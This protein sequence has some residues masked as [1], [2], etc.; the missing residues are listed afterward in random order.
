MRAAHL[1]KLAVLLHL[2]D[3]AV[4]VVGIVGPLQGEAVG[5][6]TLEREQHGSAQE[7]LPVV[8]GD[9]V[10]VVLDVG[11]AVVAQHHRIVHGRVGGVVHLPLVGHAVAVGV[12]LLLALEPGP[13][14]RHAD[15]QLVLVGDE[16]ALCAE[17]E[18][19]VHHVAVGQV[20]IGQR[21]P[22][23]GQ[24]LCDEVA[25]VPLWQ[26][27][28]VVRLR[29]AV[30]AA[31]AGELRGV[32][33]TIAVG[34]LPVVGTVEVEVAVAARQAVAAHGGAVDEEV[35]LDVRIRR[36]LAVAAHV[37]GRV[38]PVVHD[39]V[40]VLVDALHLEVA[41]TV[42]HKQQAVERDVV[43]LHQSAR[44]VGHQSLA[45]YRVLQRDVRRRRA[46]VVPV[47]AEV[48]VL[49][50]REGAVVEDHVLP[51]A[52]AGGVLVLRA[53]GAHAEAHVAADEVV[54]G[55]EAHAVA[56]DG[57]TLAGSRLPGHVEVLGEG[58]ARV[59]A[60]DAADIEDD[61]AVGLAHGV[62]Q[63]PGARVVE[64]GHVIHLASAPAG[65]E[66]TPALGLGEG[67]RLGI[68]SHAA[69]EKQQGE[70]KSEC[71]HNDMV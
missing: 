2:H 10:D 27:G 68:D 15:G 30:A 67:Q 42:I 70:K 14:C 18:H 26:L 22:H 40:H 16:L 59:D 13:R 31:V 28:V 5:G 32:I 53:H 54:G 62:A 66:A 41:G 23:V 24:Q 60:D 21:G 36:A 50:P 45:H 37:V 7:E 9:A 71:F 56:I 33:D 65:G 47:D 46:L 43:G 1:D 52:D 3:K 8:T 48:L 38:L 61:D 11:V 69:Q 34:V 35:A 57:D 44:R 17:G 4:L 25:G 19:L 6:G 49:S 63:R 20:A 55:R 12:L 39:V 29:L 64:V 51:V 58:D